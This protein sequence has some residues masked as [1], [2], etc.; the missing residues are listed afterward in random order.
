MNAIIWI[1][2]ILLALA[3]LASGVMKVSQPRAKLASRMPYVNDLSDN[4]VKAIGAV[5]LL[6]AIGVILPAWTGIAPILTPIAATGLAIVMVGAA[7]THLRR[8]EHQ[9][10]VVN[11]ALFA[12]AAMVAILRFGP[13]S[14]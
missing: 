2:Q 4:A 10:I 6:G 12:V 1:F 11:A 3:F 9:A 5:E 14:Y 13:Y 8:K 7:L